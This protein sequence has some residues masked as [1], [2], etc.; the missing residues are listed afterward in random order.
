[1]KKLINS[2]IAIVLTAFL[3]VSTGQAQEL[4]AKLKKLDA[5]WKAHD[6]DG[7]MA[8]FTGNA[9]VQ[10]MPPP[11]DGGRYEGKE[12][13]GT[14]VRNL[15]PNFRVESIH[16][17][18][19]GSTVKWLFTVHSDFFAQMGV[20]PVKG[21]GTAVFEK[22]KITSFTPVFDNATVAKMVATGFFK[23]FDEGMPLDALANQFM[24]P[25]VKIHVSSSPMDVAAYQQFGQAFRRAFP[26]GK[27]T[28][29]FQ[30]AEGDKVVTRVVYAGTHTGTFQGIPAT[31]KPI[32]ITGT[33][34]GRVVDGKIVERWA[35]FDAMGLMQQ[36]GVVPAPGRKAN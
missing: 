36:L 6:Y 26:D 23:A 12:Q 27:H 10:L 33:V 17:R 22:D 11:P 16:F 32:R 29:A 18:Q 8:F 35:E 28:I 3:L 24:A 20:N 31:N 34:I 5:A 7:I 1:M 21:E 19:E 9:V 30:I 4:V 13:V 2:I 14:F 25:D 15:L